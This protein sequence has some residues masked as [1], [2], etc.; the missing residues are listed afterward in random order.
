MQIAAGIVNHTAVLLRLRGVSGQSRS[1]ARLLTQ[2]ERG[3]HER[4]QLHSLQL[5]RPGRFRHCFILLP[6]GGRT[7]C[8]MQGNPAITQNRQYELVAL[9]GLGKCHDQAKKREKAIEIL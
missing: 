3:S 7:S 1:A 4:I 2:P 6:K 8:V 9:L 5:R